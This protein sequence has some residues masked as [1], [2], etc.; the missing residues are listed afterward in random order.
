VASALYVPVALIYHALT[1][2]A[3]P[4]A[5][6]QQA[7]TPL[8]GPRSLNPSLSPL[9]EQAL[10]R[11]LQQRPGNRYQV[12][13]EMRVALEMVQMMD[14]R[15]LGLGP[16]VA[17]PSQLL[18]PPAPQP[19]A[20]QTP[21]IYPAPQAGQPQPGQTQTYPPG[22]YP[23]PQAAPAPAGYAQPPMQPYPPGA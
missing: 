8:N 16:G 3:P 1:G 18:H 13:S 19:I 14:G 10:L 7:G 9:M 21:G 20:P 5:E 15:S 12:A 23:T 4:T 6:Q 2:W 22:I 11:G 17:P